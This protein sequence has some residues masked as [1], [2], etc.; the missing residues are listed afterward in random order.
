MIGLGG[1]VH[2][3]YLAC[4]NGRTQV[5]PGNETSSRLVWCSV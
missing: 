2:E 3:D 5:K 1:V 4:V